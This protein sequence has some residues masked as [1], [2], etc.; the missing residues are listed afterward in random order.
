MFLL[1]V[2]RARLGSTFFLLKISHFNI[3]VAYGSPGIF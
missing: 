1:K 3:M 2:K